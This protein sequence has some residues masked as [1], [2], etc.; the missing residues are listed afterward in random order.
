M[1]L[2]ATGTT[3]IGSYFV[4]NYPP[5]SQWKQEYVTRIHEVLH[6]SPDTSI[7]MGLYIHIPFCRKRCKFC[8]FRVYEKQN[9]KTIERYVQA[10]QQEF[11]MLSQVEAIKGRT[12]DFTY[13]G[14]GTP[15]Y[16]SSKQLLSV[17]DR[18]SSLLSWETAK[19]VTFECEPGTLNQEK[20]ETL[21]EIGITRISLGV[22]SF[23]DKLLE[24]NGRAH[25]T[26]EVYKAYDWI[27][28]VGF[29]QVNIDLIAGMMGETDENWSES[30]EKA[31]EFAPDNITIYQMELPH[32][33]IISKEMKEMGLTSPI[34]D[35]TTKRRWMN[36]A[37]E[38]L[39][40]KGYHLA[41]GNELVKNP[42]T[43]RF[44]Y[45]DN[46]FRGNDIIAT[47]VSSFGHMQ[48]VHYQNL[49]RLEDYLETVEK[50]DLPI[51]RA[52][53]P[54]EH[55]RLIREF[56]LQL[57]EGRVLTQPFKDKFGV[58]LTEEFSEALEN[59][60]KAG[61]LTYDEAQVKLTRKGM[62]Q[63]DSLL[64][65]YFEPEHRMVRYT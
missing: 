30:V 55:Q 27:Q 51:N 31:A 2:E 21:K 49:D 61:Y 38:T 63:A 43:D 58:D 65:E 32:N 52:L 35:W 64:T 45:R 11:E 19:E 15:S 46:L 13:F 41:S 54:S 56:I 23:N 6:Q 12:L 25:L 22:E 16:L 8:Y 36:E 20:V 24:A 53:E 42:E 28:Q 26:P 62:L 33:T 57:K 40:A 9:A 60:Q 39:Q 59:Q 3:E 47:G 1:D 50:G 44:V 10:L 14:G 18:L 37:I 17:R 7:P 34:A 4:S 5:F 29:P 48:G